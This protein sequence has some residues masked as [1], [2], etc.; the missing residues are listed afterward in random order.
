MPRQAVSA[1]GIG[2][3]SSFAMLDDPRS[4]LFHAIV[5]MG[6]SLTAGSL[7]SCGA[8]A[9]LGDVDGGGKEPLT[10]AHPADDA[11]VGIT[12]YFPDAHGH[13]AVD[14]GGVDSGTPDACY[15][16]ISPL[17]F[18]ARTRSP[19]SRVDGNVADSRLDDASN[20]SDACYSCIR[21]LEADACYPCIR[22][23]GPQ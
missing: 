3:A 15:A 9:T 23:P 22:P 7:V 13:V 19:D 2:R 10:D 6:A 12:G 20:A 8:T 11:Y 4:R 16:C 1:L 21:T 14:G 5:V 17:P 18:D